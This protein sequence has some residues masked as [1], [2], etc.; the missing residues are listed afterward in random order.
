MHRK[1]AAA[2]VAALALTLTLA[3]CG[4]SEETL[5]RAQLVRR[6]ELACRDGQAES[7]RQMRASRGSSGSSTF[8]NAVLAG[9]KSELDAID[10]FDV[11]DAAK[12]D[13]ESFKDG[14]KA[15]ID[16]IERVAAAGRA[17]FQRAM[18]AARPQAEAAARR[19][20]AAARGLGIQGCQ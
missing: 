3:S 18:A 7:Q 2:L 12:S 14:V 1:V 5:T 8:I 17:N 9:Q 16:A 4:G 20:E 15:R 6:V 13:Y 10:N 19:V 11:P